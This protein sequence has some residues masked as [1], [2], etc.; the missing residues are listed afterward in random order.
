MTLPPEVTHTYT[1]F[2]LLALLLLLLLNYYYCYYYIPVFAWMDMD[3]VL[4]PLIFQHTLFAALRQADFPHHALTFRFT[5]W[6]M[7]TQTQSGSTTQSPALP[8]WLIKE[9]RLVVNINPTFISHWSWRTYL[10]FSCSPFP[11]CFSTCPN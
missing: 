8:K 6:V 11:T 3:F 9:R 4:F 10:I 7:I 2:L 1:A 5:Q